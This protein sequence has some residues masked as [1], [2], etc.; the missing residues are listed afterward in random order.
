MKTSRDGPPLCNIGSTL[1][2][3]LTLGGRGGGAQPGLKVGRWPSMPM[4]GRNSSMTSSPICWKA[5]HGK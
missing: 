3:P 4:T 5:M 2:Q 1:K